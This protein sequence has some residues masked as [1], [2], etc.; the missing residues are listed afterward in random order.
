VVQ[1]IKGG[2]QGGKKERREA[3]SGIVAIKTSALAWRSGKSI[4]RIRYRLH[5]LFN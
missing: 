2:G 1:T 4:L 5:G 3:R